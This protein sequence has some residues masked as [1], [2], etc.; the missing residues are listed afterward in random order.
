[1]F[2]IVRGQIGRGGEPPIAYRA[3]VRLLAGVYPDVNFQGGRLRELLPA[4]VARVRLLAGVRAHVLLQVLVPR[5][6]P[7]ADRAGGQVLARVGA[8]VLLEVGGSGELLVAGDAGELLAGVLHHVRLQLGR[9]IANLS[10]GIFNRQIEIVTFTYLVAHS[11]LVGL[12]PGVLPHVHG[13]LRRVRELG[14]AYLAADLLSGMLS[15]VDVQVRRLREGLVADGARVRSFPGVRFY[16][17]VQYVSARELLPARHATERF[18]PGVRSHVYLQNDDNLKKTCT[19]RGKFTAICSGETIGT[20]KSAAVRHLRSQQVQAYGFSP[21][22][23]FM[24][25][26]S[27]P[28]MVNLLLQTAHWNGFSPVC[29][30]MCSRKCD[31]W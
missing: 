30:R 8:R 11:A 9:V 21:V 17:G 25:I 3:R 10:P 5:E 29:L 28:L 4:L 20:F 18:L 27:S 12:L 6:L 26:V 15:H 19:A 2:T 23:D 22:W 1:M 7:F 24:C 16:V 13:Q 14:V 31:E